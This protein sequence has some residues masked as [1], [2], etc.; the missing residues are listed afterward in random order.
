MLTEYTRMFY[1]PAAARWRYL[2]AEAMS[3]ARAPS[4]WKSNM[5]T[6]WP[7][8]AIKDVQVQV[9]GTKSDDLLHS[10][11]PQ[12]KLGSDLTV[13]ALV[14]LGQVSPDDVSVEVYHGPVDTRGNI[15]NGSTVTMDHKE[16]SG[17]NGEHWFVGSMPCRTSGR[18]GLAVRV[19]PRHADLVN[20]YDLGLVLWETIPPNQQ[21]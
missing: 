12:L 19:L 6:A 13:E 8:F 3:R 14:K 18:R 21:A 11:Q 16:T 15:T 20:P 10:K 1:N 5:K 2:T 9:N 4:M 17:Q 7:G